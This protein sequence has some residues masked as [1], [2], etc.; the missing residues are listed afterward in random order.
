[1][2]GERVR[3]MASIIGAWERGGMTDADAYRAIAAY[4]HDVDREDEDA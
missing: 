1:M 2:V 4:V 3:C